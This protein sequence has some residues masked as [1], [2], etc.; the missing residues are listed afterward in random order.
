VPALKALQGP[1]VELVRDALHDPAARERGIFD[2]RVVD[3]LLAAPNH[4]MTNLG[5]NVLWQVG[6]L[7][8]WLQ[9]RGV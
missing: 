9:A 6:V 1:Y 3:R 7:E 5:G 8:L 4:E 2:P